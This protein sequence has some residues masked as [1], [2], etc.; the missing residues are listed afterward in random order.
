MTPTCSTAEQPHPW[1]RDRVWIIATGE[2]VITGN[3]GTAQ[4]LNDRD[5]RSRGHVRL[6]TPVARADQ[7]AVCDDRRRRDRRRRVGADELRR[8]RL[9]RH[10]ADCRSHH[11]PPG[12]RWT[13]TGTDLGVHCGVGRQRRRSPRIIGLGIV[14]H[15]QRTASSSAAT[16]Q[17]FSLTRGQ[18][19]DQPPHG[20]DEL[21]RRH[22]RDHRAH[23]RRTARSPPSSR[24]VRGIG[25][26]SELRLR[27]G[28]RDQRASFSNG[29]TRNIGQIAL[30][31]FSNA[32]GLIDDGNGHV[33][34][35]APTPAR[36]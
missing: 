13:A 23:R 15:G 28:R 34:R 1:R 12:D 16:N 5:R 17:S 3:E 32:E 31:T 19:C 26:L 9:P 21:Q 2:I 33:P 36:R 8:L 18:R 11:G 24:T 14:D 10:A 29:L 25:T 6:D 27:R 22:E 4:D 35:R 7:P 30:A 20:G